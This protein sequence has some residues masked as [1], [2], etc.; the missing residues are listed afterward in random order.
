MRTASLFVV[1]IH[2]RH[3]RHMDSVGFEVKV[4][5]KTIAQCLE[6]NGFRCRSHSTEA[7]GLA[8]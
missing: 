1:Y 7:L 5:Y 3:T 6:A 2:V 8:G 4:V